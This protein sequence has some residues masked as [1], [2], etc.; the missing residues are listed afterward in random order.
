MSE[1]DYGGAR[2]P[3][4][5]QR[6]G[7]TDYP[8]AIQHRSLDDRTR[9]DLWNLI[10]AQFL[11]FTEPL[12]DPLI[13]WAGYLGRVASQYSLSAYNTALEEIVFRQD[14]YRVYDL[15]QE[16]VQSTDNN[17]YRSDRKPLITWFNRIL[18]FNRAGCRIVDDVVTEITD[19]AEMK[20]IEDAIASASPESRTHIKNA[21]ILL[22]NRDDA[23]YAKSISESISAVEAAARELAGKPKATLADALDFL[24]RSGN[25]GL[26]PA[27]IDG[28]KK[29]YGFTSDDGGIRHALREGTIPPTQEL[30]QYFVVTCSAFVNYATAMRAL[31]TP[32]E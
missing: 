11:N 16:L 27:L 12:V 26:H 4:F 22:A 20:A 15:I 5:S 1:E 13:I 19:E 3:T 32:P 14:W 2:P 28:W 10:E 18:T 9:V 30:A 23:Q 29:L 8:I 24:T 25:A 31:E 6:Y 17:P 21:L 7:F